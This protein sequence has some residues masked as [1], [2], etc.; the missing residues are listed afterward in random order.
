MLRL[1]NLKGEEILILRHSR[2]IDSYIQG[3]AF[4]ITVSKSKDGTKEMS[5]QIPIHIDIDSIQEVNERW[6]NLQVG[7]LLRYEEKDDTVDWYRI[8][9]IEDKRDSLA[10]CQ[11]TAKHM[12]YDLNRKGL[13]KVIDLVDTPEVILNA[14]LSGLDGV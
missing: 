13:G 1:Y 6:V 5:F 10:T 9:E 14:I 2:K 3:E 7:L 12:S 11:I 8:T 4:E